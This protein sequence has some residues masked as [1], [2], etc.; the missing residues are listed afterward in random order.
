M[1]VQ[2][3]PMTANLSYY[4]RMTDTRTPTPDR[5]I[6]LTTQVCP[7]TFVR[8]R[9]ALDALDPGQTLLILLHGAEPIARVPRTVADL[10]HHILGQTM[11]GATL[12]LLVQKR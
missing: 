3:I 1:G 2:T 11:D 8:T 7:M 12:H 10:G 9:L 5:T 4:A 6:D